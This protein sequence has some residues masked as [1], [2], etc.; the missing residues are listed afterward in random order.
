LLPLLPLNNLGG[1]ILFKIEDSNNE[2]EQAARI[3]ALLTNAAT[4]SETSALVFQTRTSG[5]ALLERVRIAGDGAISG[6]GSAVTH[7]SFITDSTSNGSRAIY[8]KQSATTT[9]TA[10]ISGG[11][12]AGAAGVYGEA[13][14]S[15]SEYHA[16]VFGYDLGSGNNSGGVVGAYTN[17]NFGGLGFKDGTGTVYAGYFAGDVK[18]TGNLTKGGGSFLIDHP[19]DPWNKTLRHYFVE[20]PESLCIYRGV[21]DL[22]DEGVGEF[23]LPGYFPGLTKEDQASAVLTSV[24]R[25][26][27]VGYEWNKDF[28]RLRVFGAP[29]RRVSY[30]VLADRDDPTMRAMRKPTEREKGPGADCEKGKL[31]YPKAYETQ[32]EPATNPVRKE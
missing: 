25:P 16:G 15:G 7:V 10:W 18:I 11:V 30:I 5:G 6:T 4:G 21:V 27:E 3:G 12:F 1:G 13:G 22:N 2:Q 20:S 31:L 9:K 14:S 17:T 26:F 32:G 29:G 28:T 24:G 8:G 23:A 19:D